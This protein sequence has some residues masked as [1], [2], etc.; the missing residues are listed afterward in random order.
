MKRK[1]CCLVIIIS[2]LAAAQVQANEKEDSASIS[3]I[4]GADGPTSIFLAGK[5]EEEPSEEGEHAAEDLYALKTEYVGDASAIGFLIAELTETGY[6][7]QSKG[8]TFEILSEKEPYGLRILFEEEPED[9]DAA[10][11]RLMD[12]GTIML[13]LVDNLSEIEFIYPLGSQEDSGGRPAADSEGE[14]GEGGD[15]SYTLY[16]D[17]E[18]AE[19][20]LGRNVKDYGK[21]LEMFQELITEIQAEVVPGE[22]EAD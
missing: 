7:L 3:I 9:R 15:V 22:S 10:D 5:L 17:L 6:L 8:T 21:S 19:A 18:S 12:G 16:W 2:M 1:I 13:A 4:G 11:Q 20:Y 14:T